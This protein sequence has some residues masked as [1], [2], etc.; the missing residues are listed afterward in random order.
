MILLCL[1]QGYIAVDGCSLTVGE[2][3]GPTFCVY[4]IPE[5]L[6]VTVHGVK[7]VGDM[8]N[9]EIESQTQVR[10]LQEPGW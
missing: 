3:K 8:V 1:F 4:L 6:R 7:T 5:T 9:I 10:L 2:V